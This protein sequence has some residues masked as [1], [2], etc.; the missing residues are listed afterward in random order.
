M[1]L[2]RRL[3][4]GITV[5]FCLSLA[6]LMPASVQAQVVGPGGCPAG[7]VP[8]GSSRVVNGN[9]A[10]IDTTSGIDDGGSGV[11]NTG[12]VGF[13]SDI[14]YRGYNHYPP[15]TFFALYDRDVFEFGGQAQ[16]QLFPGD[17]A[18][19]IPPRPA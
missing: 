8:S 13:S 12:L 18:Y 19:G 15:D 6:F 7:F 17:P 11:I 14:P 5:F 9:F 3:F 16:V 1:A 2:A 10:V 4:I